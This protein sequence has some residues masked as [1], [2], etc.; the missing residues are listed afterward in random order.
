MFLLDPDLWYADGTFKLSRPLFSR[1]Y[2]LMARKYEGVHPILY[3]LLPD[4]S[5]ATYVRMFC[6]IRDAISGVNPKAISCDFELA[7]ISA[8]KECFPGVI[9]QG[10]FFHL[11]QNLH[12]QVKRIGLQVSYNND[13]EL[14]LK[15][16]MI[17][18]LSF[19]PI[20]H[21]DSY[22]DALSDNIPPEL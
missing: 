16:K 4:R 18:A 8:M 13:S 2:V 10:C 9:V 12:K 14:A 11:A 17:I 21:L 7:A 5:R 19:V 3:A 6:M 1:V 15:A 22:I 20:P